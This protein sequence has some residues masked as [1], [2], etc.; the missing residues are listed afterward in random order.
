MNSVYEQKET[1]CGCASCVAICPKK[2]IEMKPDEEGFLYP[3]INQKDCVDC[4]LCAKVCAFTRVH[5]EQRGEPL[6]VYAVKLRDERK[7][8]ESQSG[9]AF[10][11]F[12]EYIIEQKGTVYGASLGV[13]QVVRHVRIESIDEIVRL[14]GSKYV[15]SEMGNIYEAVAADLLAQRK[16]LFSGTPCQVG[17]VTRF[18]AQKGIEQK[19]LY[20]CDL[21]CHG[22]P[23]PQVFADYLLHLKEKMRG[24]VSGFRFR[25][26]ASG[27]W[28]SPIESYYGRNK[29]RLSDAY[30]KYFYERKIHRS[31]CHHCPYAS[32]KRIGDVT[33]GDFWGIQK[34][35][36]EI[37]DNKGV[38]LVLVNTG[39]GCELIEG[40][41]SRITK[42]K[43]STDACIQPQLVH[44][45]VIS[46]RR[47]EFWKEYREKGPAYCFSQMERK[48][49]GLKRLALVAGVYGP[50]KKIE[51]KV[52]TTR[53]RIHKIL[54]NVS[55]E[56]RG[57]GRNSVQ[58]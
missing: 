57:G 18:L 51:W 49:N 53:H 21:V 4:G 22:V 19:A 58:K 14:K 9:G 43:S 3:C 10:T 16:A 8:M 27:G 41:K 23:S 52:K 33:V 35:M 31:C 26:K 50:L 32:L 17:G 39:N 13:D 55:A 34:T 6:E 28:H 36:P 56:E 47:E 5:E 54:R 42:W 12:A 48:Q 7:R 24:E 29:S 20:T 45:P 37:D 15:Q 25:N 40:T 2:A 38:S 46:P 1:C 44:P 11:A 30:T